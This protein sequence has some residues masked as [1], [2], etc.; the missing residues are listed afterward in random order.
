MHSL[1]V[2]TIGSVLVSAICLIGTVVLAARGDQIP[3][4]LRTADAAAIS[5]FLVTTAIRGTTP[6]PSGGEGG[7][8]P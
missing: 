8:K 2:A 7:G 3:D 1:D 5:L 4:I 6:P